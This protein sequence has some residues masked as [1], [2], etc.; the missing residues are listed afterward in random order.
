MINKLNIL[1]LLFASALV[2]PSFSQIDHWETVVFE[3]DTWDYLVPSTTVNSAWNTVGFN[4]AGWSTGV[5]GFGYGDGDDNT[6]LPNGTVS[7]YQRIEFTIT[8][9]SAIDFAALTIDYDDSFV[10]Y[11]NGVEITRDLVT[12]NPPTWNQLSS[13]LHE[14]LMYQGVYPAQYSITKSF[15]S[16]NLNQGLNVLAVEIHNQSNTSSDMSSRVFL[17][18]GI[19]NT[20]ADYN[21]TPNWFNPPFVFTESNL[22]I[23]VINT[24]NN[25]AIVD[26]PKIDAEM[27]IINNGNGNMNYIT[28]PFN[29]FHGQI[30][31]EIRGSSSQSFPK[32]GYGIETRAPDSSNYNASIFNWPADNDWVLHAPYSDKSLI[33]NVLTYKLGNDLGRY[34][35]RT[36]LCEV[37]INGEYVGVYVF[38]EKI[39]QN[40]GRVNVQ[41]LA[42]DDVNDN[43]ITGG[44]VFKVDKLTAGGVVAWTSPFNEAPP[45]TSN[46]NYQ[47]HDPAIDVINPLQITYLETYVTDFETALSGSNFSDPVLGYEPFIDVGSFVDFMIMNEISKNVDGYRIST[48]YHKQHISDGG[49]MVAGPLWDFNLAWGNANYCQGDLTTGWEIDFNSVCGGGNPFHWTRLVQDPDFTR[50]L[51]CRWQELRQTV[52]HEDTIMNYIDSLYNY[53]DDAADRNFTKWQTLG[54]YV[55]PNN[56]IG[57]TYLEEINYVKSWTSLRLAWLDANMFGSCPD[58]SVGEQNNFDFNVFPN[59]TNGEINLI[60]NQSIPN[61]NIELYNMI[62]EKVVSKQINNVS[63]EIL[64]VNDLPKGIYI[65]KLY[66]SDQLIG[67]DKIIK[68]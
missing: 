8:D 26:E 18:L 52:L 36:Q 47:L 27:G 32:K 40:P 30:G 37:V 59:P 51:N 24:I 55:W 31:I 42:Y 17:H 23:V 65:L 15:L 44:Y 34:A 56:Y 25:S 61:G 58:L 60:F 48:F 38:T 16:A 6:I 28:D 10:A 62:G 64:I 11:L 7:C 53:L 57:N 41:E 39:K 49:L 50:Q 21:P 22:P 35:P 12:G 43:E 66:N 5:G 68:Q 2:N 67:Q 9:T 13:G 45:S 54:T 29:E 3:N 33:R 20:S 1:I 14:A 63:S 4:T 46:T 19:N